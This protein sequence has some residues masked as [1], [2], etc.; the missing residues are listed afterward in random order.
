MAARRRAVSS[1]EFPH[2]G[3]RTAA[4]ELFEEGIATHRRFRFHQ[5]RGTWRHIE[6]LLAA[7]TQCRMTRTRISCPLLLVWMFVVTA[8]CGPATVDLSSKLRAATL[9]D[10]ESPTYGVHFNDK[11]SSIELT[12]QP[13]FEAGPKVIEG[14]TVRPYVRLLW[15]F[16]KMPVIVGRGPD[17][18]RSLVLFDTGL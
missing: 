17:G 9:P 18:R 11:A 14:L 8:G 6:A 2:P 1:G 5:R 4:G 10:L 13:R 12:T 16:M 3:R 15:F 7:P